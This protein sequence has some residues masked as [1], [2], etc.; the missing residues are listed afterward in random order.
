MVRVR[1]LRPGDEGELPAFSEAFDEPLDRA[2]ISRFLAD[3]RH[4]LLVAYVDD[5]AA[6]FLS[7]TEILHPDKPRSELFLNE[8]GVVENVRRRGAARALIEE[9]LALGRELGCRGV[10]VLTDDDNTG[11]MALYASTGGR[12]DPQRHRMFDYDL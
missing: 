10:Y 8:I 6:G 1:R 4:H 3:P 7:A 9:L 12:L 2:A 5:A 11:A